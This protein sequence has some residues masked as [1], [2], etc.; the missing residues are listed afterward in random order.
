MKNFSDQ[1][2]W[3]EVVKRIGDYSEQPDDAVWN[4]ISDKLRPGREGRWF[5]WIERGSGLVILMLF[6]FLVG[7]NVG[8][9]SE[10]EFQ[11]KVLP[12]DN[13]LEK[14]LQMG[15]EFQAEPDTLKQREVFPVVPAH[16]SGIHAKAESVHIYVRRQS[17]G[18]FVVVDDD[19]KLNEVIAAENEGAFDKTMTELKSDTIQQVKELLE[20]TDDSRDPVALKDKAGTDKKSKHK[21]SLRIYG[22]FSP[23][24]AFQRVTPASQDGIVIKEILPRSL[25]SSDRFAYGFEAG[26]QAPLNSRLEYYAGISFYK[27]NQRIH[28]RYQTDQVAVETTNNNEYFVTPRE[29]TATVD[30]RMTN[31]GASAGI[32]YSFYGK[33]LKHQAGMGLGYQQ[34]IQG[35]SSEEYRN[36]KS[37]YLSGR[38][39]YRNELMISRKLSFY[40]QPSF[41]HAFYAREELNAPFELKPYSI[42]VGFGV[43][44][45]F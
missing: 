34:G 39:F 31:I 5:P 2:S 11:T 21:R 30:Y 12:D 27:Q 22:Q 42:S 44:Y 45:N 14:S 1:D 37:H 17:S 25:F 15:K 19:I 9:I 33:L 6:S 29:G 36:D 26:V 35:S 10:V 8:S 38:I 13:Q 23:T 41:D 40:I 20:Q 24:I 43:L 7:T 16:S 28:Y 4:S 18:S 32:I 3:N